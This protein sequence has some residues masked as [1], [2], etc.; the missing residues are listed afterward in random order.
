M[1]YVQRNMHNNTLSMAADM[2]GM[3]IRLDGILPILYPILPWRMADA[4]AARGG[5]PAIRARAFS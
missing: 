3:H 2:R 1:L 5:R 4:A